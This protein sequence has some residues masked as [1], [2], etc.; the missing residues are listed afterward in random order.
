M[1]PVLG[2]TNA[3]FFGEMASVVGSSIKYSRPF[4][5]RSLKG[6]K[7]CWRRAARISSYFMVGSILEIGRFNCVHPLY[8]LYRLAVSALVP[9]LEAHVLRL[10]VRLQ[11]LVP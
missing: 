1:R 4:F 10:Q 8:R 9:Q 3:K 6:R 5:M 11:P 7:G 2:S